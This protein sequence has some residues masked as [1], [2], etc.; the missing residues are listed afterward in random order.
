MDIR[1]LVKGGKV[2]L[3]MRDDCRHFDLRE[4]ARKWTPD[5]EHPEKGIGI[6]M[7]LGAAKDIAYTNTMNANNLIITI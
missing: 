7:V 4:K 6:R 3:R 1:V 5:P 2:I